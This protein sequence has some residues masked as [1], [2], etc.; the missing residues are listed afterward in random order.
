MVKDTAYYDT[1]GVS[2]DAPAAEIKKAYYL[3]VRSNRSLMSDRMLTAPELTALAMFGFL[4]AKLVH[5]DKNPGN[6]DAARK[7]QVHFQASVQLRRVFRPPYPCYWIQ[8]CRAE[9][10]EEIFP[11][12]VW[13]HFLSMVVLFYFIVIELFI[14]HEFQLC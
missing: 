3:K 13:L 12:V 14:L 1:L 2:T 9:K 7:F 5:P 8:E 4:Q 11:L 6:P 10:E